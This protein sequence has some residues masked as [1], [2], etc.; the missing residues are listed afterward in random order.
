MVGLKGVLFRWWGGLGGWW[1]LGWAV[2]WQWFVVTVVT[3]VVHSTVC[4][5]VSSWGYLLT[6]EWHRR[7]LF[8]RH[9]VLVYWALVEILLSHY[10][11]SRTLLIRLIGEFRIIVSILFD[12]QSHRTRF[13]FRGLLVRSHWLLLFL[14]SLAL[15]DNQITS[16]TT[17]F[18]LF[19]LMTISIHQ[20]A[21]IRCQ[22]PMMTLLLSLRRCQVWVSTDLM[23]NWVLFIL[24][25]DW[26]V[27][28]IVKS[29][30]W[31]FFVYLMG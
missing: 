5:V 12:N 1:L 6:A 7:D 17:T 8:N 27:F 26:F 19:I 11:K 9:I 15:F 25:L 4:L 20:I 28:V 23:E 29:V 14:C 18:A 10:V 21:L 22:L 16:F 3:V 24:C 13:F 31:W 30:L 2:G